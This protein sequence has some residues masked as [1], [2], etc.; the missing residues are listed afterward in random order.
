MSANSDP[1]E[2]PRDRDLRDIAQILAVLQAKDTKAGIALRQRYVDDDTFKFTTEFEFTFAGFH[3]LCEPGSPIRLGGSGIVLSCTNA[4]Q[5]IVKYALKVP[6][7]S[8]FQRREVIGQ[9]G[10]DL[11]RAKLEYINHA[12][13][14]HKNIAR[15]IAHDKVLCHVDRSVTV[16]VSALL[17]EW[18]E[19]ALPLAEYLTSSKL[20]WPTVVDLLIQVFDGLAHLHLNKLIHWDIKSD[21]FLVS[22]TGIPKLT[23]IGNARHMTGPEADKAYSTKW[24][25]PPVLQSKLTTNA[26]LMASSRKTPVELGTDRYWDSKW[27]DLWMFGRELNRLF[28]ADSHTLDLDIASDFPQRSDY[29]DLG[30]KFLSQ[31]FPVDDGDS[32]FALRFIRL[33]IRRLLHPKGPLDTKYYE[34]ADEVVHD[35]HKLQTEFGAAQNISELQTVPQ[36]VLRLPVSGNVPLTA[37]V[38]GF[39]NSRMVGRLSSHLQLGSVFRIYPGATHRRSEHLFGVMEGAVRF[40]RSLFADRTDP[41]WRISIEAE[42]VHALLTAALLHDLGHIAYGHE[43]EEMSGLFRSRMH[44]DYAVALATGQ[45]RSSADMPPK[46]QADRQELVSILTE[47][48]VAPTGVD[49]FLARVAQ[50]LE[51]GTPTSAATN[52]GGVLLPG[53][54]N[55]LKVG[56]LHSIINSALDA[57]ELDYL[58]RDALYCGVNYPNGIDLDRFFQSLTTITY[59]EH[60]EDSGRGDWPSACVGVNDKGVLPAESI[61]V[62]RYQMFSCVYWHHTHRAYSAMLQLCVQELMGHTESDTASRLEQLIEVFREESDRNSLEW[63]RA[64]LQDPTI[65][66]SSEHRVLLSRVCDGLAGDRRQLYKQYYELPYERQRE[67][68]QNGR[69]LSSLSL[70]TRLASIWDKLNDEKQTA[71]QYVSN[72]REL[73]KSVASLLSSRLSKPVKFADGE[74]LIDIPPSNRDQIQDVYVVKDGVTPIQEVSPV[75]DGISHAFQFWVRKVRVF[76]APSAEQKMIHAG[77]RREDVRDACSGVMASI[78][79]DEEGT[80]SLF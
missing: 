20:T 74:I 56:I 22:E 13:L 66:P 76:V 9:L 67:H 34:S 24:N 15:L 62:A 39:L 52:R 68:S 42:D 71:Y 14:S 69:I 70:S 50:I 51:P 6:R 16:V 64:R 78:A 35:L 77:L 54:A 58:L 33:I 17:V 57:D 37:L 12:P 44:E 25:L 18:I 79:S 38:R 48:G 1:P 63:L 31:V 72:V 47:S 4:D 29:E 61:F 28:R 59:Y 27:L 7:P 26:P 40:V 75:A 8:E 3:L 36:H 19:G 53:V 55:E 49:S 65:V 41:F 21:N 23:D 45:C 73:R 46:M 2:S 5:P 30:H 43:L 11:D 80:P 10:E 32:T 60:L